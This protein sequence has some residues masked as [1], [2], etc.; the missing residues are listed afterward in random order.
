MSR[1][2]KATN[3]STG[4]SQTDADSQFRALVVKSM[5]F[6]IRSLLSVPFSSELEAPIVDILCTMPSQMKT[7]FHTK[8]TKAE[9]CF[10]LCRLLQGGTSHH[11]KVIN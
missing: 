6:S 8:N 5:S 2:F 4:A 1:K 7:S 9:Q 10:A 11:T 3:V